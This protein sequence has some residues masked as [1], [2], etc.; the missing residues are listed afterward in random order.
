MQNFEDHPDLKDLLKEDDELGFMNPMA[1]QKQ[2]KLVK[3]NKSVNKVAINKQKSLRHSGTFD[4]K[5]SDL[6]INKQVS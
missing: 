4:A 1:D 2:Q 6:K 5:K 3:Q